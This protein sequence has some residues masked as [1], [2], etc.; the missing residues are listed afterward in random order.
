VTAIR[1]LIVD[2]DVPT[3]IGVRTI[4]SSEPDIDVVGEAATATEALEMVRTTSPDIVL[5]DV[6]LPDVDGITITERITDPMRSTS[7]PRVIMLT[8]FDFDEY[9]YRS[10]E[11][12]A[13]GFLLK[14]TRAEDLIDAIRTVADGNALPAP[15]RTRALIDTYA[16]NGRSRDHESP[17]TSRESEVLTLLARGLSNGEIADELGLSIETVR[18]HVK[19]VYMKCG[20]RDRVHAV[21]VAYQWG[22]AP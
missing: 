12:G 20:A 5:M 4:L 8:T 17:L 15:E 14:R 2:D 9:V 21:I 7:P 22:L 19:H 6:Q 13:S 18:T 1:T 16:G 3:R 10:L 11:A